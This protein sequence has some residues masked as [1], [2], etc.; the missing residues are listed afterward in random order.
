MVGLRLDFSMEKVVS[1][2]VLIKEKHGTLLYTVGTARVQE[3]P[4]LP[5]VF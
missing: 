5:S 1:V 2:F 3:I 4:L